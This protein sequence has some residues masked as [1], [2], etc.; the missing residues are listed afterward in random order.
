MKIVLEISKLI[1]RANYEVLI[2]TFKPEKV[3]NI[4]NIWRGFSDL[5][6]SYETL[7]IFIGL[8][9]ETP[10]LIVPNEK[11]IFV[12]YNKNIGLMVFDMAMQI[13]DLFKNYI[14]IN[15]SLYQRARTQLIRETVTAKSLNSEDIF[16]IIR[17]AVTGM[18]L[19]RIYP[20]DFEMLY[21]ISAN[22]KI[23]DPAINKYVAIL[24]SKKGGK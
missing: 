22:K 24:T 2:N 17:L 16:R 21:L 18:I 20:M 14:G 19:K 1:P 23:T 6:C 11:L 13:A 15:S 5:D 7:K 4:Y 8:T 3:I 12:N 10:N 9:S